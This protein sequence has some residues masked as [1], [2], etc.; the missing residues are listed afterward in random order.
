TFD[1][2]AKSLVDRFRAAIP[3][4]YR[5]SRNYRTVTP[6]QG[7]YR[8]FLEAYGF[9]DVNVQQFERYLAEARL[10]IV[11]EGSQLQRAIATYWQVQYDGQDEILLTFSMINRLAELLIRENFF[12]QKALLETYPIVFLD[13]FQDTTLPQFEFLC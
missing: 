11:N 13:E 10:P 8:Q 9:H 4:G 2:F 12:I 3:D 7:D 5:P 1:A 6:R